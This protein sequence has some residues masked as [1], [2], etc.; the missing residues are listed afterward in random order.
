MNLFDVILARTHTAEWEIFLRLLLAVVLGGIIGWEREV[1]NRPAGLRT[2]MLIALAA[3]GFSIMAIE[4]VKWAELNGTS[5]DPIRAIEAVTAGVAFLAAGTI[6]QSRGQVVGLTTGAGMWLAGGLGV[7]A[8]YGFYSI[9]V[10]IGVIAFMVLA[11]LQRLSAR[12][13]ATGDDG[14]KP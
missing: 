2:H 3:A 5:A 13:N 4:L 11:G 1:K 6:I 7:A 8:G 10:L 14:S 9:A 12:I